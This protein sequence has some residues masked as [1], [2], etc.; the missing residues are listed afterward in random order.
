M[1]TKVPHLKGVAIG[2]VA[3]AALALGLAGIASASPAVTPTTT[4]HTLSIPRFVRHVDVDRFNCADAAKVLTRIGTLEAHLAAGL[5]KL[6]AA[7]VQAARNGHLVRARRLEGR[8]TRL[9]STTFG[10][11]LTRDSAAIEAKC[12]ASAPAA[13]GGTNA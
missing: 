3:A 5:P 11:R 1:F 2:L 13:R 9:E 10:A 8:I 4:T 6:T 7:Q 12:P